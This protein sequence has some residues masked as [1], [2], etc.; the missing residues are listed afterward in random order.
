MNT[1]NKIAAYILEGAIDGV[2][3]AYLSEHAGGYSPEALSDYISILTFHELLKEYADR[4]RNFVAFKTTQKGITYLM[5][6]KS[7]HSS[8]I[9][10]IEA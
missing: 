3:K 10:V 4:G 1:Q 8:L 7:L 5:N 9:S 2:T 6:A